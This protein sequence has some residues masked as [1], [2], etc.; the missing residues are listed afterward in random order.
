MVAGAIFVAIVCLGGRMCVW[1][2]SV[3]AANDGVKVM[4]NLTTSL[5][6]TWCCYVVAR[7]S[8]IDHQ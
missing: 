3:A 5:P 1:D 7:L 4:R 2:S 8:E 6:I